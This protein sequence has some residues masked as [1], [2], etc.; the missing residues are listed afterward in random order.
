MEEMNEEKSWMEE[1]TEL[2]RKKHEENKLLKKLKDSVSTPG[3]S[4]PT[5]STDKKDNSNS[6]EEK[7]NN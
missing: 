4:L 3:D 7:V 1:L 2:I 5:D 6:S